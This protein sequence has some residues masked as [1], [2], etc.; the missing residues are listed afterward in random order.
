MVGSRA[1]DAEDLAMAAEVKSGVAVR[2]PLEE[3]QEGTKTQT[4]FIG[5]PPGLGWLSGSEV[6]ERFS[7]Y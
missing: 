4:S 5:H 7:Y 2:S 3:F 6:W 1:E